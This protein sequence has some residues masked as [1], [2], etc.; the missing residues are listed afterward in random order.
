M[1]LAVFTKNFS[2]PAYVAARLGADRVVGAWGAQAR[3]FVPQTDDDA[4][5][6]SALIDE[7]IA[8]RP[9]AAVLSPV[10]SSAVDPAI[11]RLH[12]AG[13]PI[14]AL[15]T[16]VQA[17][18]VLSF[19]HSDDYALARGI[20]ERLFRHLGGQGRVL[21]VGGHVH[22]FTSAERL[23]GFADAARA[24]PEVVCTAPLAGDYVRDVACRRTAEWLQAPA[25]QPPLQAC[26]VA[27]DIMA[28][29]VIDALRAAGRQLPVV[30]GVNAIPEAVAAIRRGDM[31][32]SA[33]FNAMRMA[34]IATECAVRH[35]RG[36]AVPAL[37]ELPVEIVDAGNAHAWDLPYAERA[38]WT[39]EQAR[40]AC[41]ASGSGHVG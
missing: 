2:N 23:R 16:P 19:V 31:L 20:A 34:A 27:N 21:V 35:L 13:V 37:V 30:V 22:S 15:V 40:A 41:A 24:F 32:A 33:D 17:V 14:V 9:D 6:Q 29:G 25:G 4:P 1:R 18:P 5:Q 7:A 39:L 3:H 12:A 38:I 28:L 10:H 26:L 8:W 11:G 36:E